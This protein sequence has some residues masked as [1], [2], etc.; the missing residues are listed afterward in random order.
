M[1]HKIMLRVMWLWG[2]SLVML[3]MGVAFSDV[4]A[5]TLGFLAADI[6]FSIIMLDKIDDRLEVLDVIDRRMQELKDVEQ[7]TD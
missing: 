4:P 7:A 6:V 3:A 5:L 1:R 2:V